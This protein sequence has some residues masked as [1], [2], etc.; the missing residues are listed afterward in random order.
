LLSRKFVAATF[1]VLVAVFSILSMPVSVRAD[2]TSADAKNAIVAAQGKL[3]TCYQ[4]VANASDAGANV[5][6]LIQVLNQAGGNL[7][8]ADLEYKMGN[9]SSAQTYAD[10]SLNLLVQ[11][12][13]TAQAAALKSSASHA[14]FWSFMINIVGSSVGAVAVVISGFVIWTF[15][16]RKHPRVGGVV[17]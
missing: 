2:V 4:A 1:V 11:N 7:S 6:G 3:V 10:Q 15:L 16:K 13:V 17:R 5:T 14:R 9:F 12:N 8:R